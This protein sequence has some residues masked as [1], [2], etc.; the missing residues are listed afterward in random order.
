MKKRL[1]SILLALAAVL[2]LPAAALAAE[3]PDYQTA[4]IAQLE[5]GARPSANNLFLGISQW[6]EME[7]GPEKAALSVRYAAIKKLDMSS[8][9]LTQKPGASD[10]SIASDNLAMLEPFLGLEELDLSTKPDTSSENKNALS[11]LNYLSRL[12][13]LRKLD[14]SN[15]Q[16]KAGRNMTDG[17][18]GLVGCVRLE[19]LDLSGNKDLG[20]DRNVTDALAPLAWLPSLKELNLSGTGFND[21]DVQSV[22]YMP[23]LRVLDVSGTPV[24]NLDLS[25]LT[26]LDSLTAKN[27]TLDSLTLPAGI[28][29]IDLSGTK[30]RVKA[31][32][33][34]DAVAAV[35]RYGN[36]GLTLV[37]GSNSSQEVYTVSVAY[38]ANGTAEASAKTAAQETKV[39]VAATPDEGYALDSITVSYKGED[40]AA[41]SVPVTDGAFTMPEANVTVKVQFMRQNIVIQYNGAEKGSVSFD[42]EHPARGERVKFVTDLASGYKVREITARIGSRPVPVYRDKD[43]TYCF[44]MPRLKE[45]E[46]LVFTVAIVEVVTPKYT[47]S[48]QFGGKLTLSGLVEGQ[49]YVCQMS[50]VVSGDAVPEYTIVTFTAQDTTEQLDVRANSRG[51]LVSLWKYDPWASSVKDLVNVLYE[52]PTK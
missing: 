50:D 23:S 42:R 17:I 40:G 11:N 46:E 19:T 7:E 29:D 13:G 39:T 15:N 8:M 12:P 44:D 52:A 28:T 22:Q 24:K 14:A 30:L 32:N 25:G 49:R 38:P 3:G 41:V 20:S 26:G 16:L 47:G 36:S 18:S 48:G 2:T 9:G 35:Q 34:D 1:T 5:A 4:L 45:N 33:A 43:G 51:Y 37:N 27:L 31:E 10:G 21:G 6:K